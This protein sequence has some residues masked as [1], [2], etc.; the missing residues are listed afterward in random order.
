MA[1]AVEKMRSSQWL[2]LAFVL[3]MKLRS[4][5]EEIS[6]FFGLVS[7]G[8]RLHRMRSTLETIS[9][10]GFSVAVASFFALCVDALGNDLEGQRMRKCEFLFIY[11]FTKIA[12]T[13]HQIKA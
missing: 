8:N 1:D 11:V 7:V 12:T 10:L 4:R 13:N 6:S 9:H 3:F 2:R 5:G